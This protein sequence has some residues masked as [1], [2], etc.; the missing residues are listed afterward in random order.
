M[1]DGI[2]PLT[3]AQFDAEKAKVA[4]EDYPERV[5]VA[6]DQDINVDTGGLPDE[7][8]SS[9]VARAATAGK[10]WGKLGSK[11][12]DRFQPDHGAKAEAGDTERGEAV[13]ATE[14]EYDGGL[15]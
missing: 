12:L 7:T 15:E 2:V 3:Q 9:R 1:S 4:K 13:V 11:I 10:W 5:A 14:E 8:I 6:F